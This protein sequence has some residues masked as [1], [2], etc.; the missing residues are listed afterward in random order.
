MPRAGG[1]GGSR[2][3][4]KGGRSHP[5]AQWPSQPSLRSLARPLRFRRLLGFLRLVGTSACSLTLVWNFWPSIVPFTSIFSARR[6]SRESRNT[7]ASPSRSRLDAG[8][9]NAERAQ[10]VTGR[11]LVS[12]LPGT[13]LG[14]T[15]STT[16]A[17]PKSPRFY[18]L[19]GWTGCSEPVANLLQHTPFSGEGRSEGPTR[20]GAE[21]LSKYK[22]LRFSEGF[23][24]FAILPTG[25]H[26][27]MNLIGV[28]PAE[29]REA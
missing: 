16:K 29:K 13:C 27:S 18:G 28:S 2:W 26:T 12:F 4:Q 6:C 11:T 19:R 15:D 20:A 5:P 22:A 10:P 21:E 24:L 7:C 14:L 8:F 17:L 3:P 9:L 1:R 25:A 23:I